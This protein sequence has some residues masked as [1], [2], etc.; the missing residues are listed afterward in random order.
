MLAQAACGKHAFFGCHAAR[1]L[2]KMSRHSIRRG[3]SLALECMKACD[4]R[5]DRPR[6]SL[7]LT[8]VPGL[9]DLFDKQGP[10]QDSQKQAA[11]LYGADASYYLVNGTTG[12][13]YAILL[14]TVGP[15]EKIILPPQCPSFG[16]RRTDSVR[17]DSGFCQSGAGFATANR[18]ECSGIT[19]LPSAGATASRCLETI[20]TRWTAPGCATISM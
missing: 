6:F 7:D 2:Q 10:I 8:C 1:Y 18:D 5:S 20:T 12:G 13:I 4:N 15:G 9:G 14:T 17:G 19:R 16:H 11:A 3:I